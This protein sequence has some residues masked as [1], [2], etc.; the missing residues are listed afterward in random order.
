MGYTVL[1]IPGTSW[2]VK[3]LVEPGFRYIYMGTL[4]E[5]F[6]ANTAKD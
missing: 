2:Y 1:V 3:G 6:T 5:D 4:Y